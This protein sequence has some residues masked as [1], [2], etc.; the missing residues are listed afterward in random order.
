M[1]RI[2]IGLFGTVA[3]KTVLNFK[4]IATNGINGKTYEGSTFHRVIQRFMIQG[5]D[6]MNGDGTSSISIYDEGLFEDEDFSISHN[7][8]GYISMANSGPNTNG[9]QFFIT[10]M[11]CTWLDG[12]H[13]VFGKVVRGQDIVH[14]IE[15]VRTDTDDRPVET[16][17]IIQSGLIETPRPFYISEDPYDYSLMQWIYDGILPLS[18]SFCILG[19]FQ[20]VL[21][22]LNGFK[23][24]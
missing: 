13:V 17:K 16:V 11:A 5:G 4:T 6:I 7:G 19:F 1:G 2:V 23:I 14:R 12:H 18:F 10:T 3:P 24:V 22:K 8:A 15:H 9:C 20:W 21:S